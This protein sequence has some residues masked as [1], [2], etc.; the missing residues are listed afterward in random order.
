MSTAVKLG[1]NPIDEEQSVKSIQKYT[2]EEAAAILDFVGA[3]GIVPGQVLF[4]ADQT[5]AMLGGRK[6]SIV[7]RYAASGELKRSLYPKKTDNSRPVSCF[8]IDDIRAFA[9]SLRCSD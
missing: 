6:K 2:L 4:N 7:Y 8:H 5:G 1:A 9:A 3:F